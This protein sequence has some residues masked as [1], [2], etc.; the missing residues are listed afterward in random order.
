MPIALSLMTHDSVSTL[1]CAVAASA[2]EAQKTRLRGIIRIKEGASRASVARDFVVD[3]DTV[4]NW[5][6]AYNKIAC[7]A[8]T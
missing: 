6:K 5:I 1:R 2:D 3:S 4:T 8:G 7:N